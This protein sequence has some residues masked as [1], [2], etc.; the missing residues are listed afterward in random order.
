MSKRET[1]IKLVFHH[2]LP[3]TS[4]YNIMAAAARKSLL[5]LS[6]VCAVLTWLCSLASLL[7]RLSLHR[8]HP[9]RAFL[10]RHIPAKNTRIRAPF[11][12]LT[13]SISVFPLT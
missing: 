11:F 10:L 3:I 8:S 4:L 12:Q 1:F 6:R 7:L 13:E 9:Q 5:P 2:F